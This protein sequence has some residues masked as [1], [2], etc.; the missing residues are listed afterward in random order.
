[1]I[2]RIKQIE[3]TGNIYIT[4]SYNSFRD[5]L[6]IVLRD[7]KGN[8]PALGLRKKLY[9]KDINKENI[10][11]AVSNFIPDAKEAQAAE[12]SEQNRIEKITNI[13]G[14]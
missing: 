14:G 10:D 5:Y 7:R 4:M 2:K 12:D 11:K 13:V 8:L 1:M 3:V 6:E 9:G